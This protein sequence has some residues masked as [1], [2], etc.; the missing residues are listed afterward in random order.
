MSKRSRRGT[1]MEDEDS[2]GW[3]PSWC[4]RASLLRCQSNNFGGWG[5]TLI[6]QVGEPF[7]LCARGWKL[8]SWR[9]RISP[10]AVGEVWPCSVPAVPVDH[11]RRP[12]PADAVHLC[13]QPSP[14]Q[15]VIFGRYHSQ[16]CCTARD[17]KSHTIMIVAR[18]HD[19]LFCAG[20]GR[21]HPSQCHLNDAPPSR[22][23]IKRSGV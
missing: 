4:E 11:H 10:S 23:G 1:D 12:C 3:Q 21:S 22:C 5:V 18:Y 17:V 9:E 16:N 6:R 15:S 2:R 13:A 7:F 14:R 8:S 19:A 20:W